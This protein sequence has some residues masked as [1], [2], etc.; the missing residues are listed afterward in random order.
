MAP[1]LEPVKPRWIEEPVLPDKYDVCA[2]IRQAMP[3][4]VSNGEHEYTRWGFYKLLEAEAQD[5]IQPDVC[6]AGGITEAMKICS[7]ASIY[8]VEVIPHG[9]STHITAHVLASQP[10]DPCPIQEYLVKWNTVLQFF[11]QDKIEP[12]D[13][14]ITPS[15][16]PGL[17]LVID[18]SLVEEES[19]L[20]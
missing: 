8:E 7:L 5:V 10:P 18:E 20:E 14:Y 15:E 13:G 17:G 9:H 16:G 6:W 4:P 19:I 2:K 3:F 11:L 12:V 1:R